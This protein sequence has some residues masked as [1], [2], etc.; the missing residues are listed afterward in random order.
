VPLTCNAV[1]LT[2]GALYVPAGKVLAAWSFVLFGLLKVNP[3]LLVKATPPPGKLRSCAKTIL[4]VAAD[5]GI[6]ADGRRGMGDVKLE[7]DRG[8]RSL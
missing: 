5:N 7:V 8:L 2:S 1:T 6:L 4:D 3:L